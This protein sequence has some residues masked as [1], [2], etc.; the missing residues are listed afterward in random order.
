MKSE[1][2]EGGPVKIRNQTPFFS[3]QPIGNLLTL[4]VQG[5]EQASRIP[6]L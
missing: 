3:P 2:H 4:A 6:L 1:G 5:A